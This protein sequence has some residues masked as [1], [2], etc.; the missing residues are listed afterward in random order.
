MVL[1]KLRAVLMISS[2]ERSGGL[3]AIVG[4]SVDMA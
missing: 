3:C 2:S 1:K 4:Y